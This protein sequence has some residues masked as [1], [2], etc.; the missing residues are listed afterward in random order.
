MMVVNIIL[1]KFKSYMYVVMKYMY[2][3]VVYKLWYGFCNRF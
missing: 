1:I 2:K 3:K